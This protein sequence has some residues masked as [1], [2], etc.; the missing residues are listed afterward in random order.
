MSVLKNDD[1]PTGNKVK[2][3]QVIT[4]E[5]AKVIIISGAAGDKLAQHKV[6]GNG[7]LLV[8]K[9][10]IRFTVGEEHQEFTEG[11]GHSIPSEVIHA[12]TCITD[13]EF[14]VIIPVRSKI[15]FE[16]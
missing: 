12:V 4:T 2:I 5:E 16:R 11:E 13:A 15:K 7:L 9:G 6:N 14:F 3:A 10:T 1:L 8:K